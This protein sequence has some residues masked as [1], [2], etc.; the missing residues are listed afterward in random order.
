MT[1]SQFHAP[2]PR[3]LNESLQRPVND[4][5]YTQVGG[6]ITTSPF[7]QPGGAIRVV[8]RDA[9]QIDA[10]GIILSAT[11]SG[12][13]TYSYR[14][15]AYRDSGSNTPGALI[16]DGGTI[17]ITQGTTAGTKS[18]SVTA[19]SCAAGESIW[20]VCGATHSAAGTLPAVWCLAGHQ[21]PY[22]DYGLVSGIAASSAFAYTTGSGTALPSTFSV[23][24][25][26]ETQVI[27]VGVYA[28]VNV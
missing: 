12:A 8:F 6:I 14:V 10:L 27:V 4:R 1:D 22:A 21:Q 3:L 19:F 23:A 13:T 16:V 7:S 5:W 2:G 28:Q 15:G 24:S 11:Y 17:S 26:Q 20:L 25:P 18:V 9:C